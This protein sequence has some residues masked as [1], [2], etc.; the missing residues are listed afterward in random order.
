MLAKRIIPCLDI[1]DGQTV[2]GT[3]FVNLRQ[4]GDPVELAR[5]YSEQGADE[6][7]F[8]D[9]TASFEGRKTFTELVKRIAANISIPFTV[10]GGI[11]EL[12]DVD[13]LLNAGAD[14]ISINSSAIRR[15]G[16]IDE[17]AQ[18]FALLKALGRTRKPI[19]LKRGTSATVEELLL[20]AEYILSGGNTQ[21]I[22]CERGI[23]SGLTPAR[24]ALDVSAVPVLKRLTHLP[25]IVDPSHAAGRA[26]LVEPLALAAVA[27]GADGL[28]VEVHDRPATALSDGAQ[29]LTPAAFAQLAQ[30]ALRLREAL[31]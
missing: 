21:V 13:R 3:N 1:K 20:S 4:A 10:G 25:V 27:A 23:R 9:I 8:L 18:N 30:K 14:K 26:D 31:Q 28:L 2:K 12:G 11:H 24:A 7:V 16:L 22:L 19:L 15:P 6:L 29:S 17:I 5:A